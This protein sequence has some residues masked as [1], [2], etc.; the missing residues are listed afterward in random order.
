MKNK[1]ISLIAFI[2]LLP[3]LSFAQQGGSLQFVNQTSLNGAVNYAD[4]TVQLSANFTPASPLGAVAVAN[5]INLPNLFNA[6]NVGSAVGSFLYVVDPGTVLGEIMQVKTAVAVGRYTVTRG[7]AGTKQVGHVTGAMVLVGPPNAFLG[8][9]PSGA[10][11]TTSVNGAVG[12]QIANL[13]VNLGT[14]A[15]WICSTVTGTWVPGWNNPAQDVAAASQAVASAAGLVTPSGPLFHITGALAITGFNLPLGFNGGNFTVIPD[16]AF[17]TT[18]AN[19]IAIASTGVVSKALSYQYD[20][21][22]TKFYPS[23]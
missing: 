22:S 20:F 6:G 7:L 13:S 5:G 14:G 8:A 4:V 3:M 12:Q 10:C 2:V 11:G 18:N 21:A 9:N 23:Y 1:L 19:N 17:T 16:G 15:E